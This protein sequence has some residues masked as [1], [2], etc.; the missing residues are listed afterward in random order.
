LSSATQPPPDAAKR[1]HRAEVTGQGASADTTPDPAA[2]TPGPTHGSHAHAPRHRKPR[3]EVA[4]A[5][6]G[7]VRLKIPAAKT[8]PGLL[9]QIKA[10]FDGHPGIDAID[11]NQST[12][13]I[14]IYYDPEH[15]ADI[16]SL[17]TSMDKTA[18]APMAHMAPLAAPPATQA[19]P[20]H[21]RPTNKLD[22]EISSIADEAEF[23]AEHSHAA[24]AIVEY[25]KDLDRQIKRSTNNNIDLKI[26]VPVG[27]AAFTILEIGIATATPMWVTLALFSINHFVELHA[28]DANQDQS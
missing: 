28:H 17:F 9:D 14:V 4:H 20:G 19:A 22:E 11:V 12:G 3:A 1:P 6:R 8:T 10:A 18:A 13:S 7:R 27:L 5:T 21:H 23:L 16:A 24:R 15:H 25:I 2:P 26:L